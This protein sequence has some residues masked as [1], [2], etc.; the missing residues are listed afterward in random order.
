[1]SESDWRDLRSPLFAINTLKLNFPDRKARLFACGLA[2]SVWPL[3]G[4]ERS[5]RAVIVSEKHA[6]GLASDQELR[7]AHECGSQC[8]SGLAS[9]LAM[10]STEYLAWDAAVL[11]ILAIEDIVAGKDHLQKFVHPIPLLRDIFGNPFRPLTT[12]PNWLTSTVV[13]IARGVY[14]E[15]A[16]Y[17]LPL[18]ADS[19][20]DA[21]CEYAQ[22]L[23]HCR[24]PGPHVRG[25]WVIDQLLGKS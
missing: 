4:D 9:E 8:V 24:G 22:I 17:R 13:A 15:R 2:R 20:Q 25:C 3:L 11:A 21:G 12:D 6:D 14:D 1:M 7:I 23:D 19:L 5:H 16:F 18:L 10:C